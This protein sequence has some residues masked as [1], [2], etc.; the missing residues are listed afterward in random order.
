MHK[1]V[2]KLFAYLFASGRLDI[3]LARCSRSGEFPKTAV[4]LRC[5]SI[6]AVYSGSLT[7]RDYILPLQLNFIAVNYGNPLRKLNI[8]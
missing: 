7:R 3:T 6:P 2:I 5:A 4:L 1:L 8:Q